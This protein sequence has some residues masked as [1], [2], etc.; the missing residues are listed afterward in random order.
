MD[1]NDR[2]EY[3]VTYP[4]ENKKTYFWEKMIG[5][6]LIGG[7]IAGLLFYIYDGLSEEQKKDIKNSLVA[8]SK[9]AIAKFISEKLD[10]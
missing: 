10:I 9:P 2:E 7:F 6:S 5:F 4:G 8:N 3:A 1:N